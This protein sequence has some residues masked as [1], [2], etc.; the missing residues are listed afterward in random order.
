VNQTLS[1]R[2]PRER[3]I[4]YSQNHGI[5]A[6]E[7]ALGRGQ[8]VGPEREGGP[9]RPLVADQDAAGVVGHVQPLVEVEGQRIRRLDPGEPRRQLGRQQ[10]EPAEGGIDVEPQALLAAEPGQGR[11]VVDRPGVDRP[12]GTHDAE[13]LQARRPV[14]RERALE[15]GNLHPVPGIDR[16]QAQL[17]AAEA[18]KLE[19]LGDAAMRLARGVADETRTTPLQALAA[20]VAAGMGLACGGEADHGRHR[21]A[22][23]QKAA[24]TLGQAEDL[25]RPLDHLALDID[26]RMLTAA[27]VG[28]ERPGQELGQGPRRRAGAVDP[29]HEARVGVARG[30]GQDEG[31]EPGI[32]LVEIDALARQGPGERRLHRL[33]HGLPDRPVA[34]ARPAVDH[35]VHRP[36]AGGA[37][38]LPVHRIERAALVLRHPRPFPWRRRRGALMLAARCSSLLLGTMSLEPL[39]YDDRDLRRILEGVKTIAMVGASTNE[40]RPS[41]FA[42]LYLQGKGYRVLPVNPRSAG[43]TL[44]SETVHPDL[45]SLPVVPD[46]VSIFRRSEEAGAVAEE[47]VRLGIR[48]V[49]MQLGVRDDAA[50]ERLKA[51]GA[52]VVMDRCPKIEYGRLFGEIGWLGVNRG[53]VSAKRGQAV[54]L[55]R[56]KGGLV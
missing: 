54:Q 28:V 46:M 5:A 3:S 36:M 25:P 2:K 39:R 4:P 22:A 42:M 45:A 1:A 55:K 18:Q 11:K 7:P 33:G 21:G 30:I 44:L 48:V 6:G 38:R 43:Q 34:H 32:G 49:W 53:I 14:G 24:R 23:D 40:M 51:R 37:E 17:V 56:K 13:G 50:A 8:V 26:G 9:V 16:D 10:G 47:A 52:E 35:R 41:Y 20:H 29:A 19:R 27:E 31:L 12:G 15:C